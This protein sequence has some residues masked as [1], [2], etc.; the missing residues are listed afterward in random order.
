M[1][2]REKVPPHIMHDVTFPHKQYADPEP[3]MMLHIDDEMRREGLQVTL[4]LLPGMLAGTQFP[5]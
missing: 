1:Q 3:L 2:R 4:L 5:V